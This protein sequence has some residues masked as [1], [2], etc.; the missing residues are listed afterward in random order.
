[1]ATLQTDLRIDSTSGIRSSPSIEGQFFKLSSRCSKIYLQAISHRF[2]AATGMLGTVV[3]ATTTLPLIWSAS[4]I[5]VFALCALGITSLAHYHWG[6]TVES[7]VLGIAIGDAFGSGI[8]GQSRDWIAENVDFTKYV[9]VRSG[10]YLNGYKLGDYSDDTSD[11]IAMMNA[12][13]DPEVPFSEK[14]LYDQIKVQYDHSKKSRG[15]IPRSGFGSIAW[16]FRNEM[17]IEK[18]KEFQREKKYP[19]NAPAMRAV[20]IGLLKNENL[21]N[22]YA[23]INADVTHPNP[24]ARA[25][26]IIV[27]RAARYML[28]ER[29]SQSG[30]IEYCKKHIKDI[31]EET[32]E[33]LG[34]IDQL[35]PKL[36]EEDY[37][38]L[39]CPA[40]FDSF[41]TKE[42]IMGLNSDS[43]RTAGTMLYIVKHSQSSFEALKRSI[44]TGG[45]VD[46]LAAIVMG[47][48]G[49]RLGLS[50]LPQFLFD[51]LEDREEIKTLARRF[52]DNVVKS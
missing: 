26:S 48:V 4:L 18:L 38:F 50:D 19:G 6:K 32:Y 22:E 8:E 49:G 42:P 20:A 33:Y 52:A 47:V 24:K 13:M 12:L 40:P 16:V 43:M 41:M 27:A 45:D 9:S 1:M 25:A 3:L 7:A 46:S 29:G 34:K 35:G 51:G 15:G 36:S 11:T 23:I 10:E 17:T 37:K 14:S 44:L 2:A 21:I 30:L 31:D 39:V 5:T 28:V